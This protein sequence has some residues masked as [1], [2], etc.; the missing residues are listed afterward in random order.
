MRGKLDQNRISAATFTDN[1]DIIILT[2]TWLNE[3]IYDSEIDLGPFIIYRDD[4]SNSVSSRGGGVLIA[5]K[6][7]FRCKTFDMIENNPSFNQ[8]F[9]ILPDIKTIIGTV[10]IP[11]NSDISLYD[12]HIMHTED[13]KNVFLDHDIVL[14]GDYNLPAISWNITSTNTLHV[15]D[16]KA[17]GL[18]KSCASVL[19]DSFKKTRLK[20]TKLY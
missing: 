10:Y 19:V 14:I 17:T 7:S 6:K 3:E 15:F 4:R 11:P 8:L 16:D 12:D 2:E 18:N 9:I 20:T 5:V 13:I 1:Y